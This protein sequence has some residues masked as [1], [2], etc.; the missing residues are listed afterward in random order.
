MGPKY[1]NVGNGVHKSE[2]ICHVLVNV[3][4]RW[5]F[6]FS[7]YRYKAGK[8]YVCG[9]SISALLF[10]CGVQSEHVINNTTQTNVKTVNNLESMFGCT[11]KSWRQSTCKME[12]TGNNCGMR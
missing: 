3:T 7:S 5:G 8:P 6:M 9:E 12:N 2:S 11:V 1:G 10:C 4:I